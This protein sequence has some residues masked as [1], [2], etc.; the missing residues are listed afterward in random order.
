[1]GCKTYTCLRLGNHAAVHFAKALIFF[2]CG[3]NQKL[4]FDNWE[5]T[6]DTTNY[7]KMNK[8]F[9]VIG[10]IGRI[11]WGLIYWLVSPESDTEL[12]SDAP[13]NFVQ[14]FIE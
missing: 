14:K 11:S 3:P 8:F 2:S 9:G 10:Q 4:P 13:C 5:F 6:T 1:M 12:E 7:V